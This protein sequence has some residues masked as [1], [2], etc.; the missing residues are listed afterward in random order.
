MSLPT[1]K[2]SEP[3]T[4]LF[5]DQYGEMGGG[6]TVLVEMIRFALDAGLRVK[7]IAPGSGTLQSRVATLFGS[8]VQWIPLDSAAPNSG[9]LAKL[10]H[11]VKTLLDPTWRKIRRH[12]GPI[13]V[14]GLKNALPVLLHCGLKKHPRVLLH[15]HLAYGRHFQRYL[16]LLSCHPAFRSCIA[17]SPFVLRSLLP[18]LLSKTQLV[19]NWLPEGFQTPTAPAHPTLTGVV[20]GRL[21]PE[22]GQDLVVQAAAKLPQWR[23]IFIGSDQ[24][25]DKCYSEQIKRDAGSNCLFVGQQ[26]N[27]WEFAHY[28]GASV[29]I[30]PSLWQ[31]PFGLVALEAVAVGLK[32]IVRPVGGLRDLAQKFKLRVFDTSEDLVKLLAAMEPQIGTSMK[33]VNKDQVNQMLLDSEASKQ[34]LI[35]LWTR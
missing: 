34:K 27:P 6:Q 23:F 28:Q 19:E 30:V 13:H 35:A 25:G 24:L 5:V 33:S 7:V 4:V 12:A 18:G 1:L 17:I 31:E 20:V 15:L 21:M 9:F 8:K 10:I 2:E 22:K 16:H 32:T 29:C 3:I 14:N 11:F 26:N